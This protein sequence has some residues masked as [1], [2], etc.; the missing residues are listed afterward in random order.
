MPRRLRDRTQSAVMPFS[1][2]TLAQRAFSLAM[3]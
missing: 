1:F 2:T 3:N